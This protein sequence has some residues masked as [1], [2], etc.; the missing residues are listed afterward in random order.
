M[1]PEITETHESSEEDLDLSTHNRALILQ[2]RGSIV[3]V[4]GIFSVILVYFLG[5]LF[6][7]NHNLITQIFSF[8]EISNLTIFF[9]S[10]VNNYGLATLVTILIAVFTALYLYFRFFSNINRNDF[11]GETGNYLRFYETLYSSIVD[12][13]VLVILFLYLLFIKHSFFELIS[14][15]LLIILVA[16]SIR[17]IATPYLKIIHNY[18]SI[19]DMNRYLSKIDS[20]TFG[21]HYSDQDSMWNFIFY[22]FMRKN[23]VWITG[24]LLLTFV[25][26]ILGISG[27]FNIL[28]I[29]ILE[30]VLIRYGLIISQI[31][32]VPQIQFNLTLTNNETYT[33]VFIIRDARDF[34]LVLSK[35]DKQ[36]VIMKSH[37]IKIEPNIE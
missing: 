2:F 14:A 5:Y 20:N 9:D 3:W 8:F 7:F 36:Y 24:V 34:I 22:N 37:L 17:I 15:F 21:K 18:S 10:I 32:S 4:C 11:S 13:T 19:T 12:L 1:D 31:G 6:Y 35:N 23:S 27:E 28:T 25:I 29:V 33:Q 16:I 26:A 30:L